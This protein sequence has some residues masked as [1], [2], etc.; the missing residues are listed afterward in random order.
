MLILHNVNGNTTLKIM[1][2]SEVAELTGGSQVPIQR[3]NS[4]E[5]M[6]RSSPPRS[7]RPA[8]PIIDIYGDEEDNF[9]Q[10]GSINVRLASLTV[11]LNV[12]GDIT[13]DL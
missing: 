6:T 11:D 5:E 10:G 1:A 7:N 4:S 12:S 2:D 13:C 8:S 3:G 9:D